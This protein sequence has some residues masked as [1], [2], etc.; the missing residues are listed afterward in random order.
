[1]SILSDRDIKLELA[2]GGLVIEP[3]AENAIQPA[4]VDVRLGRGFKRIRQGAGFAADGSA[5]RNAMQYEDLDWDWYQ[6]EPGEFLLATTLERI[7]V[8]PHLSVQVVGKS[9]RGRIGLQV[10]NAGFCDAG[11]DGQIT[12]ELANQGQGWIELKPGMFIAQLKVFRLS[13]P[14]ERPYGSPGLGSHYQGQAGT[15]GAR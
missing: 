6:L 13:S 3:I 7:V 9:S 4:S 14:A 11:F 1:M 15:Q 12:L 10:E 5:A 2:E 8:P